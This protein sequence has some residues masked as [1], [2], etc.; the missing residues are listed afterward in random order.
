MSRPYRSR[1]A[2]AQLVSHLSGCRA[3][4]QWHR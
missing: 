4:G 1:E 2:E 3:W